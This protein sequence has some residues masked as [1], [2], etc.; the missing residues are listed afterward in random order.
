MWF[1][2]SIRVPYV[3]QDNWRKDANSVAGCDTFQGLLPSELPAPLL[4]LAQSNDW[5]VKAEDG[6]F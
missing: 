3:A 1:G 2:A 4:A 6:H 5:S